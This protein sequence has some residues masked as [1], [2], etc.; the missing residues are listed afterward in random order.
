MRPH[1]HRARAWTTVLV[2]ALA[3][4][5]IT[6][7]LA[8]QRPAADGRAGATAVGS[9]TAE[10]YVAACAR[11]HGTALN[12]GSAP[13]LQGP[14]FA[15][16]WTE[17]GPAALADFIHE[18]MP[19]E[20]PARLDPATAKALA[21]FVLAAGAV[22][23]RMTLNDGDG[24]DA[25]RADDV[26]LAARAR[27]SHVAQGLTPVTDAML[28]APPPEDWLLWRGDVNALGF[29]RLT[30][31]TPANASQLRLVW[32]K[33]LGPGTNAI[34]PLAHDGVLFVHGGGKVWAIDAD[35]GD[36]IWS[37]VDTATP[38]GVRQPRGIA[39]YGNAV[40][41]SLVNNHTVALDARSGTV[42]WDHATTDRNGAKEGTFTAPP[43]VANGRVYQGAAQCAHLSA[44]CYMV[45]LNATTGEQ[46]WRTYTVPGDG[47]AGSQSWGGAR[48]AQRGGGGIW[49]GPS[50]DYARD[51]IVFGTGNSYALRT[52][53]R[54][55]PRRPVDAL[56][57]NT[58]LKLDAKTGRIVWHFQHMP[59]DV[60]DLDW[61]FERM[62]ID[63]PRG[64]R[65]PVVIN[66]GKIG[67]LDA[68]DYETGRYRWSI[69]LGYQNIV[70]RIDARSGAKTV[71]TARIPLGGSVAEACPYAEGVR[72]WPS[73]S[74][75]PGRGL[76][77]VAMELDTCMRW[78]VD[79]TNPVQFSSSVIPRPGS[80][81]LYGGWSAIDL[82]SGRTVW[83]DQRRTQQASAM[84][85]TAGGVVFEGSRDRWFRARDSATGTVLWN[86]RLSDTPNSFPI[87]YAV[88]GRQYV[89]VV[90]G[91]QTYLDGTLGHLTPEIEPSLGRMTLS[92]FAL[93]SPAVAP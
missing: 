10:L 61:S 63:D 52:L 73:T 60:W 36:T 58:T 5:T 40:Y 77:F 34:A 47:D 83:I 72:N 18:K 67:I 50:F 93:E 6:A 56:Y 84:L 45:A 35:S 65:R 51:Q 17:A 87:T 70:T 85:A 14:S 28:Q 74:Y 25:D 21:E 20:A 30:Q 19:P 32:S 57:T 66:L 27:L 22:T 64:S 39:L 59:G 31:I 37:Y 53:L 78:K 68:L 23:A 80:K 33:T 9:G 29:S 8:Q 4:I 62:V 55:D 69:D 2:L 49:V 75:D 3:A 43:L 81:H 86:V 7:P 38:G 42:L 13:P 92:V 15:Q 89:A 26:T 71:D 1:G 41:A 44:R 88:R 12:G 48:A 76:L 90:T 46:L 54:N 82:K 79:P 91:G 24:I 16:K 11:C